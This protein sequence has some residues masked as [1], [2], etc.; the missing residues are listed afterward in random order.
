VSISPSHT[1][2]IYCLDEGVATC[3]VDVCS[4]KHIGKKNVI[5]LSLNSLMR[6]KAEW[7]YQKNKVFSVTWSFRNHYNMLI[8]IN[9][10]YFLFMFIHISPFAVGAIFFFCLFFFHQMGCQQAEHEPP[11]VILTRKLAK[12]V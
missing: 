2:G 5:W 11:T 1:A 3:P 12:N 8:C 4:M 6:I 10:L 7:I 9:M